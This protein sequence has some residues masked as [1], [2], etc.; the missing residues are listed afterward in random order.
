MR[1][2]GVAREIVGV[3][4]EA[5]DLFSER[6]TKISRKLAAEVERFRDHFGHQPNAIQLDRLRQQATLA[7]RKAKTHTGETAEDRLDRWDNEL[8]AEIAGGLRRVADTVAAASSQAPPAAEWSP[9]GV[10]AE[11]L[12][13]CHAARSTFG[14]SELIRQLILALPDHLGGLTPAEVRMARPAPPGGSTSSRPTPSFP[15][16][17]APRSRPTKAPNNFPVF[18]ASPNK[19]DTTRRPFSGRRSRNGH[20]QARPASPKWF[21]V[22]SWTTSVTSSPR[23]LNT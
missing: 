12:A 13:V 2:D 14:R 19:P 1:A 6:S 3:S 16:V 11:A 9:S 17:N 10:I 4:Q 18:S 23:P 20:S 22:G 7:T 8:R 15:R 5:M 21:K